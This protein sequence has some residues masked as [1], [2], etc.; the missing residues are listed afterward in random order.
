MVKNDIFK[1]RSL[2]YKWM[3]ENKQCVISE[4]KR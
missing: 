3:M 4:C 1:K 2:H